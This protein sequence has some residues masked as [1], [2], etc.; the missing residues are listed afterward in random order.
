MEYS[1]TANVVPGQHLVVS[2]DITE[3]VEREA[4]MRSKTQ[5]MDNAPVGITL[6][7]PNL[8]DNPLV[9]ANEQFHELTGYSASAIGRNCRYLQGEETD[10]ETVAT[11]R[12]AID[13]EESVRETIRNC[14]KDGTLFWN[15]L[16]IS[17]VTDETGELM[18]W[19]GF[20][21]D[22]T[23]QIARE[24]TLEETTQRLEAIIEASPNAILAL[25]ADGTIQLW[26]DAAE[27]L[28]GY[29]SDAVIGEP[30]QSLG[31]HSD[32]QQAKFERQFKRA[33]DGEKLR[34]YE[35][36]RQT[37]NGNRMRLSI[38]TAPIRDEAGTITG[39]MGIIS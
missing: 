16:T 1:A 6:S 21:E 19:V 34:N 14:R 35:I 9:Y 31:L 20:Q 36:H 24:Q 25:D 11:I 33:L 15:R 37:K 26:N 12:R 38:S 22:V 7:D 17:P 28:F 32:D 27:D 39:V 13:E 3:R 29:D 23:H 4:E 18:N 30:I 10:S 8:E 5:A 2:R